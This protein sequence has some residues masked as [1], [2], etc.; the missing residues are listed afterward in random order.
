MGLAGFSEV[1]WVAQNRGRY[2][3][4]FGGEGGGFFIPAPHFLLNP[5]AKSP[6]PCYTV[7]ECILFCEYESTP[8]GAHLCV[9]PS[10]RTYEGAHVGAPLPMACVIP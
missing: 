6:H 2:F 1:W 7:F 5:L 4:R 10:H 3:G 8:V 9:R